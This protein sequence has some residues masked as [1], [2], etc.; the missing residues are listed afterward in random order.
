MILTAHSDA[1]FAAKQSRTGGYI[2]LGR[3]DDAT[4]INGPIQT[5]SSLQSIAT[6]CVAE[7]EYIA[8]FTIGKYVLAIRQILH[9]HGYP[10]PTSP[11]FCDNLCAVGIANDD[12]KMKR[13][14][15]VDIK[16]HWLRDRVRSK[17]LS[18]LKISGKTNVADYFTKDH[19][20]DKHHEGMQIITTQIK[21]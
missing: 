4:F 20:V 9:A 15:Y 6:A 18:V 12:I 2:F 17:D 11:I 13:M 14:K 3:R 5:V 8:A 1:D 10:Q 16:Y 7:A 19:P 21:R